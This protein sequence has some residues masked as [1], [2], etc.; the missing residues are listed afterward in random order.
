[1]THERLTHEVHRRS[2]PRIY[3]VL[4]IQALVICSRLS[5]TAVARRNCE[6]DLRFWQAKTPGSVRPVPTS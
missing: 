2:L 3:N 6:R 4:T 5:I 1:M